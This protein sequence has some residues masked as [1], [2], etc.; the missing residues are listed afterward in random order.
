MRVY[1]STNE[2]NNALDERCMN[3]HLEYGRKWGYPS[4]ILRE[5]VRGKGQWREL[6][7]SKPLYMLSLAVV[8]MAKPAD[9]RAEWLV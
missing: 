4:H 2:T 6:I 9:E 7:F 1:N 5:D 3:T 8:E